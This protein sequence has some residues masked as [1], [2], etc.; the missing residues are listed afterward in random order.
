MDHENGECLA[1]GRGSDVATEE[2][3]IFA[4]GPILS[5]SSVRLSEG[6]VGLAVRVGG[7]A[8]VPVIVTH[9]AANRENQRDRIHEL[10]VLLPWAAQQ[11]PGS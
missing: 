5:S 1:R 2:L 3:A 9:L 8:D 10:G 4:A 7:D 6:R 11:G